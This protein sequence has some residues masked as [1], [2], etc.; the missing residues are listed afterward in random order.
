MK[1]MFSLFLAMAFAFSM[2]GFAFAAEKAAPAAEK[3]EKAKKKAE[4]AAGVPKDEAPAAAPA[5]M[6]KNVPLVKQPC[7]TR[8]SGSAGRGTPSPCL[9][10][11]LFL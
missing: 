8:A 1:R 2:V 9:F 5:P 10:F 7:L 11:F 6:E 3:A 4:K